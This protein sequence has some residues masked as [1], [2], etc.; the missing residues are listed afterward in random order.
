[1]NDGACGFVARVDGNL[2]G[3]VC[4]VWDMSIVKANLRRYFLLP[5]TTAS[6]VHLLF[7]PT[8]LLTLLLKVS[9]AGPQESKSTCHYELRPI[10]VAPRF[11]GTGL[12]VSLM[13]SL[14]A[15]AEKRGFSKVFLYAEETNGSANAF[16]R[17]FGFDC[18]GTITRNGMNLN[19]YEYKL[20][21]T[22]HES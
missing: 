22:I 8:A 21:E 15:D 20:L 12:A 17:K 3:Y 7:H 4:G 1:M 2:A 9:K 5:L 14:L 10:V 11:R 19:K 18:D 16:Y 13:K 6:A